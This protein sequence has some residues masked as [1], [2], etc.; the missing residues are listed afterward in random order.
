MNRLSHVSVFAGLGL[1]MAL[2][3]CTPRTEPAAAPVPPAPMDATPLPPPPAMKVA[4]PAPLAMRPLEFP[5]FREFTLPN[6]LQVIVVEK[7]DVPVA[8][9]NLYVKSGSTADPAEKIGLAEMTAE[10]LTKGTPKRNAKQI[11]ET[12]EGVGGNLNASAG[13]DYVTIS[14]GVLVDQLPLAF[15]LM[16]DVAIRP[17]F[18]KGELETTRKRTL[19]ALQ[20]ALGEPGTLAQR[21]FIYEI[22]GEGNPYGRST[23]PQTIQA[24]ERADLQRFHSRNFK[25]D[26]ALLVVSG[27]VNPARIE[28]LAR[29]YF[30]AWKGGFGNP[31]IVAAPP[32]QG[33]AEVTL[34][35]RPGSVQSNIRVGY[36]GIRP[37][38]P[39]YYPLQVL[40]KIVGGGTD[41]RL[42]LI[43]REE[44]GWTYGAYTQ[45]SRPKEVGYFA[46]SAEVRTEVTDS[47]LT[48]MMNQLRRIRTEAVSPEEMQAAK[49]FLVG[50]FP[51]RIETAGQIAGQVAQTRLLGLDTEA[52]TRYRE[53]IAAVTAADVQRVAQQYIRPEQSTIVVVGDASKVLSSLRSVAPVALLS[54]EGKPLQPSDVE[55]KAAT[56][57]FDASALKPMT[58]TARVMAQGS[59]VGSYTS[60]LARAGEAWVATSNTQAGPLM[61][62]STVRF[63]NDFTPISS[64]LKMSQGPMS[65]AIDLRY[66]NG[67][68]VGTSKLPP[69]MGGETAIDTEVVPGTMLSGMDQYLIA[70]ADLAPG[71]T[72]SYPVFNAAPGSTGLVNATFKVT[73]ME[74]VTVPAGTFDTYR[75]E[76]SA[77]PQNLLLWVRKAAPHIVVKQEIVGQPVSIELESVQ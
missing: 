13:M 67:R 34:I 40:N 42:F 38:D 15:E 60:T 39:D 22:Y 32:A 74:S 76:V 24:I 46:A 66:E 6:G 23:L 51:L 72:V 64:E 45:L 3:G 57:R 33:P 18:P 48:E 41:A 2:G 17:T 54:V 58:L 65:V 55:V 4:P 36:V 35:H 12:I 50:S 10:L 49:S 70:A 62:E 21:R 44:K 59:A 5:P 31:T 27:D 73:G 56:E 25:A 37:E 26:N 69:Q 20:V 11:A 8:N 61:Q 68:V 47:A 52:L 9:I 43:L 14:S 29:R 28:E 75:I 1:A 77:G 71:K 63:T 19:S 16:S 53:Q 30:G 7:H